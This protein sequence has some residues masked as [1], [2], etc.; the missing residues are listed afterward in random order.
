MDLVDGRWDWIR[1]G[2]LVVIPVGSTEQHG[3]HLPFDTDTLIAQ[4]VA[5]GVVGR[6]SPGS[7]VLAP[8]VAYG[9]S[10]EHQDFPGTVS[11]GTPV[12][13]SVLVEL[14]RS[15]ATWA[16]GIVFVNGHGGNLDAVNAAVDRLRFEGRRVTWVPCAPADGDAH[17]GRA[18]TSILLHLHP[19]RVLLDRVRPGRVDRLESLL[20]ELREKGVRAV[21][22]TGVLGDP[23]GASA[24]EGARLIEGMIAEA[25]RRL[26]MTDT[27]GRGEPG[28]AASR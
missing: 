12:L 9:A 1:S 13:T 14:G 2:P 19:G 4:A 23:R 24:Q 25:V 8:P 10:G 28:R 11:I 22:P 27:D 17:A 16:A 20:P 6:M 26:A 5:R 21:S 18:E 3:P 15:A 7:A